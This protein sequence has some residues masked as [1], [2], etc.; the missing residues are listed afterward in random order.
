MST[1]D[2][3]RMIISSFKLLFCT[4]ESCP[5]KVIRSSREIAYVTSRNADGG[6]F[7][8]PLRQSDK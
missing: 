7:K 5:A 3:F 2:Y 6:W 1:F 4:A 8:D